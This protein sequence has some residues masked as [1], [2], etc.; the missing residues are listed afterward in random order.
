MLIRPPVP[1]EEIC[2]KFGVPEI[3]KPS[4][5][6]LE[7]YVVD[8][9]MHNTNVC[10][11]KELFVKGLPE[12]RRADVRFDRNVFTVVAFFLTAEY[13]KKKVD[14]KKLLEYAGVTYADFHSVS[15]LIQLLF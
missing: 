11:Y 15:R 2:V 9:S 6:V 13:K 14:K 8:F 10:R 3:A 7:K 1:F 4:K 12:N 5:R